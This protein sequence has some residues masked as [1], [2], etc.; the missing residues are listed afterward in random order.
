MIDR[1]R[2]AFALLL[3]GMS[4][5]ACAPDPHSTRIITRVASPNGQLEAIY[6]EDLSGGA[7]VGPSEDVY[8][9][10][11][12]GSPT[13]RA[14]LFSAE[15]TCNLKVSWRSGEVVEIGYY[16]RRPLPDDAR[17]EGP[18]RVAKKWLGSDPANGC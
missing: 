18:V 17:S 1:A 11:K 4:L 13:Y 2:A 10:A 14:R 9:V 15:R 16:A 12:G 5:S 7:T 8:V 6:A 3:I